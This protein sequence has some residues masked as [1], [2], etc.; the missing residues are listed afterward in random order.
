MFEI[1]KVKPSVL[2]YVIGYITTDGSLSTDKRHIN[3]TSKDRGHLYWIRNSLGLNVKVGK[4]GSGFS[5][6]KDFSY[7]CISSV[8]FYSYLINVGLT[9]KKSLTLPALKVDEIYLNDFLRGVIDGDGN[10]S[11]W[12]HKTNLN[13]QWVLRVFS[14]SSV[15]IEWLEK[16]IEKK[17][18]LKGKIIRKTSSR[19]LNPIYTLKYGKKAAQKIL[20]EVY[21]PNC[22]ALKRK[23]I[24]ARLCLQD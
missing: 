1:N 22:L 4:K 10:I 19:S 9:S 6:R 18:N 11:S 23:V 7:F 12:I 24:Q 14:G 8:S 15:F 16:Q 20:K 3:I 2:W 17:F 5:L 21:Y 13:T